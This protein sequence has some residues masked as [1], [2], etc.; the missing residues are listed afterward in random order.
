MFATLANTDDW[1]EIEI[2]ARSNEQLLKKYITLEN[3]IPSH[4]TIQRVM[5]CINPQVVQ[6]LIVLFTEMLNLD[7]GEKLKKVLCIDGKTIHGNNSKSQEALHVVSAWSREKGV[8]FGQKSVNGKGK[9]IEVIKQLLDVVSVKHQIATIDAIGT[10]TSIA[11]KIR[12]GKGD[13]VLAV[14]ANQKNLHT[15][16]STYLNDEQF[17][18]KIKE[19]GNYFQTLEKAHGK[20]EKRQY[21]QTDNIKWLE[22]KEKWCGLKSIGMV[23]TTYISDKETKSEIRYCISSLKLDIELFAKSV[24]GH[25]LVEIIHWHLDVTFREDRNKTLE[26]TAAENLNI[27][28]K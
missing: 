11:E 19:K 17:Q 6:Q 14:K 25:W 20:I 24:K 2:F 27:I 5:S 28:R 22:E 26:K 10:Q 9:E 7:E 8:S 18:N 16:I 21:Y 13:Y 3:G 1:L 15:D 4:D 23:K 12:V